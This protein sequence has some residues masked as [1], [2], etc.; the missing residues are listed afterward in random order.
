VNYMVPVFHVE[1]EYCHIA[2][3]NQ[4]VHTEGFT[5]CFEVVRLEYTKHHFLLI[6]PRRN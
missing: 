2:L 1:W 6:L 4:A 3:M 5:F